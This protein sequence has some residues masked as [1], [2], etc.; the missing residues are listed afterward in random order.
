[1]LFVGN[2]TLV[3]SDAMST[4]YARSTRLRNRSRQ[5]LKECMNASSTQ[6]YDFMSLDAGTK[7]EH[8]RCM[9]IVY[10]RW[11]F[12]YVSTASLTVRTVAKRLK[13]VKVIP[14]GQVQHEGRHAHSLDSNAI[15]YCRERLVYCTACVPPSHL[16]SEQMY[17]LPILLHTSSGYETKGFFSPRS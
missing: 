15:H 13:C 16:T 12:G 8:I 3:L 9:G 1:M 7:A 10:S 4:V 17:E 14:P 6:R 11:V 2:S 5:R